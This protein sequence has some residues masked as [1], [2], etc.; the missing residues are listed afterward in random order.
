V[1]NSQKAILSYQIINHFNGFYCLKIDLQTGRHHQIRAQLAQIGCPIVGDLKYG[2]P[3]AD[4]NKGIHLHCR[5]LTFKH[6]ITQK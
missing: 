2:Y 1:P 5:Q 6:P 3:Y 4:Q